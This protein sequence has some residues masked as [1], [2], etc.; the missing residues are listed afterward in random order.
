M[1]E[2]E[3]RCV[4]YFVFNFG[5]NGIQGKHEFLLNLAVNDI[6]NKDLLI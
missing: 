5:F 4:L 1:L 3:S 6:F 2:R